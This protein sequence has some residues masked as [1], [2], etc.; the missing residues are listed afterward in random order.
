MNLYDRKGPHATAL[1]HVLQYK[2]IKHPF[3]VTGCFRY[4]HFE[5]K[6]PVP[7][8]KRKSFAIGSDH[9]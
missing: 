2:L 5:A 3:R 9:F 4:R 6:L 7:V 1:N 8:P